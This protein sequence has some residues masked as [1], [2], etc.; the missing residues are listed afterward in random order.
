MNDHHL[1]HELPAEDET[2]ARKITLSGQVQGV[3]FRP[4]IYRLA[5][6]YHLTGWVRNCVG[7]VEIHVQGL[8]Q[9]LDDFQRGIFE[10]KPPLAQPVLQAEMPAAVVS[11]DGFD[12]LDSLSTSDSH[13][14]VPADLFL[15]DD[16]LVELNETSDR[17]YHYPFIN[18]TQC[19][20]RYTLINKLPY[21]RVNTTMAEFVLCPDCLAEY[22]DVEDRRFHAEPVACPV[23]GPALSFKGKNT[24]DTVVDGKRA[25]ANETALNSAVDALR[26]GKIV[27]VKGVGGY[28]L[29]CDA[30]DDDAVSRLRQRKPRPDK[31]LAVMFPAPIHDP[32]A[33][34]VKALT[35]TEAD[36]RFLLQPSR[37]ILLVQKNSA[38]VLSEYIAPGLNEVGMMLPYSPLHHLLLN[39]IARPLVA[40]S[41][42]ISGEPVLT[43][44]DAVDKRLS[45]V[46][47]ACLH[48]NRT[49]ARPADDPV[50]RT[51]AGKPRPLRTGRG[52]APLEIALPFELEQPVLAVG[53]HMK[54]TLTLAWG[55]RAVISPHIGEM[56]SA[57][58]LLV[59]EKMIEDLQH[60]YDVKIQNIVC[61]AHPGYST[62]RWARRQKLPVK[63]VYH[64]HAHA[65]AAYFECQKAQTG[66]GSG[67]SES[68]DRP[69]AVFTWDGVG[70][71]ADGTLWGGEAFVGQPG[72]WIRAAS[73]RPFRLP[74]GDKAGRQPWRSAAA[75]CWESGYDYED[76]PEKDPLQL[77]ILRQAWQK[78]INA[79]VS[80]SV[81]R[82]FDAAAALTGIRTNA[83][84]E[85]QG[86][87]ELEA[88]C[89]LDT[90]VQAAVIKDFVGLE[91]IKENDIWLADWR[92]LVPA[93]LNKNLSISERA[94]LF[95]QS[96]AQCLLQQARIIRDE[97]AI[98]T[99]SFS[100]GVFQNRVLTELVL[101]LLMD[102]DFEV[103]LP[104][105]IPVNDAGISF[106]QIIEYGFK[107]YRF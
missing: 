2:S 30:T 68:A 66:N 70:Y 29:M 22:E 9:D 102:D 80:S 90:G 23:C 86:P 41:A 4:F 5:K 35:L 40:T 101:K 45:H 16:C 89:A 34:A 64:H 58:S 47:D 42:N 81:G 14:T 50:Y 1:K 24:V 55:R 20:P 82:L 88:L 105:L 56:D 104:E 31:P 96:M 8:S 69:M 94:V 73:M 93:L 57:R 11:L 98:K 28:H 38:T 53:A 63:Q 51:I 10:Q 75:L 49:I 17:R 26:A 13:I 18:C 78:N 65:S 25:D 91:L 3:G 84:F 36:K 67:V 100:G 46:A 15:C 74:G 103:L 83:S 44:N 72:N 106:G 97:H 54:N 48:H 99:V 59:F 85:G 71:G 21:D 87:M 19:G 95:H 61:D 39:N 32:F 77:S 52:A 37:P 6:Q 79:P 92:P 27:A 76:I 12:I 7:I 107:N 43:E 62:T 60:L 33:F